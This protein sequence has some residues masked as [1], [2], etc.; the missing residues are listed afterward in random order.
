MPLENFWYNSEYYR[1]TIGIGLG[2][3]IEGIRGSKYAVGS[4]ASSC[5]F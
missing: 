1:E 3:G 2:Y 4:I 5:I